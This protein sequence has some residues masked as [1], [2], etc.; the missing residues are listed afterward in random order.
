MQFLFDCLNPDH[1]AF[2]QEFPKDVTDSLPFCPLLM[3]VRAYRRLEL[4]LGFLTT[5]VVQKYWSEL[6]FTFSSPTSVAGRVSSRLLLEFH[7]L[8]LR[9][10]PTSNK[11]ISHL[12]PCTI[13]RSG[14]RWNRVVFV[15]IGSLLAECISRR[16]W[17][18]G[19]QACLQ[20]AHS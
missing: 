14:L 11:S 2:L 12:P 17:R 8:K 4:R 3:L 6:H 15:D 18:G 20:G 13:C 5:S 16:A 9:G 7:A 1:P 10:G 19:T